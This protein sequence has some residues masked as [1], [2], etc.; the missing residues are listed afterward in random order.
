MIEFSGV[1]IVA[2][3]LATL[4][5]Y[6][7]A[8]IVERNVSSTSKL[9]FH[10]IIISALI[11]GGLLAIFNVSVEDYQHFT[12]VI[13]WLLGP[14]TVALAVPMYLHLKAV[15]DT[16]Y[17][18]FVPIIV[19]GVLAPVLS[20]V[21]LYLAMIDEQVVITFL[22]KSITTP[23]AMETT[24]LL[25]GIPSL[26]AVVVIVTGIVG[27]VFSK[28]I[29]WQVKGIDNTGKGLVLGTIAHAIG[30]AQAY[31][32]SEKSGVFASLALCIN[33]IVTAIVLPLIYWLV[34]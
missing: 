33:G 9:I 19:G 3:S 30:T 13:D 4:L 16:G 28:L 8:L 18:V 29:F 32:D 7:L 20:V 25:G 21:V 10:P 15:K 1:Q 24:E 22:T 11:I 17:R 5:A 12:F 6:C 2:W 27:A 14:A 23:L 26:A 31:K 34:S